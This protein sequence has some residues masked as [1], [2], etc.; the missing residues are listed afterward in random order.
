MD[1]KTVFTFLWQ[2]NVT[3]SEGEF[4]HDPRVSEIKFKRTL[5][6]YNI[7][8]DGYKPNLHRPAIPQQRSEGPVGEEVMHDSGADHIRR[9]VL[10]AEG[11]E[12]EHGRRGR[13]CG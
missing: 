4:K 7:F 8:I 3:D 6:E 9:E 1:L 12:L 11:A 2:F 13:R 5:K 10:G